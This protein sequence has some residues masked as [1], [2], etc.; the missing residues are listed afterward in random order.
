MNCGRSMYCSTRSR[1]TASSGALTSRKSSRIGR[2][3][4]RVGLEL[5]RARL[6]QGFVRREVVPQVFGVERH[7]PVVFEH[8][9]AV[10]PERAGR[11]FRVRLLGH[12]VHALVLVVD[13]QPAERLQGSGLSQAVEQG[14]RQ[15]LADHRGILPEVVEHERP[16][17]DETLTGRVPIEVDAQPRLDGI[18]ASG[19]AGTDRGIANPGVP[20]EQVDGVVRVVHVALAQLREVPRVHEQPDLVQRGRVE[21]IGGRLREETG[22]A[23]RQQHEDQER[24]TKGMATRHG[25]RELRTKWTA[26][27]EGPGSRSLAATAAAREADR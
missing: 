9:A 23:R 20:P 18:R 14:H 4:R 10:L 25:E 12:G 6:E 15:V 24:Q 7:Q 19:P 17:P 27:R 22:A 2:Y 11:E 13:E 1:Q 26:E 5:V 21:E 8:V 16:Q 3:K